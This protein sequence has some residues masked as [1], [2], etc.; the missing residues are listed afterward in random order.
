MNL[1]GSVV[2]HHGSRVSLYDWDEL[3]KFQGE[4]PQLQSE[5]HDFIVS[6]Y[7]SSCPL[8]LL[9]EPSPEGETQLLK[10][11]LLF[12]L[13]ENQRNS[14]FLTSMWNT[15]K[16]RETPPFGISRN[17]GIFH[18]SSDGSKKFRRNSM[19][20]LPS[21]AKDDPLIELRTTP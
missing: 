17:S 1:Y 2:S 9:G 21:R 5:P 12:P 14:E 6:L 18:A 19:D 16:F 13:Q 4:P 3:P 11:E 15:T 20:T 7:S 8:Q 10:S